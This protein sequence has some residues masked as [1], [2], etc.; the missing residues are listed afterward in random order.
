MQ[1]YAARA[2]ELDHL[3]L[4]VNEHQ[5]CLPIARKDIFRGEKR[6]PT[7]PG[8]APSNE[9]TPPNEREHTGPN[10]PCQA[11]A[12]QRRQAAAADRD[13]VPRAG[14][15]R[16]PLP[17]QALRRRHR[18]G[19]GR[20]L[21]RRPRDP[22]RGRPL[23]DAPAAIEQTEVEMERLDAHLGG[24]RWA[25]SFEVDQ[26]GRWEYTIEAWTDVFGTWRDELG[27]KVAAQQHDLS[28]ELS[29]GVQHL[30]NALKSA[31]NASEESLI[32]HA[33]E[34]LSDATIPESAKHD[35]ALGPELFRNHRADR[36]SPRGRDPGASR[37]R[38]RSTANGPSSVPGTSSS[39]DPGAG[40]EAS[41]SSSPACKSSAST[42][43][44]S[45]RSTRSATPI[46]RAATTP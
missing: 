2:R 43:S 35:V 3:R 34:T 37:S 22:P 31:Q 25:T 16:R 18:S 38:S 4:A 36:A 27:R 42:C 40:C 19:R 7:N 10:F 14:G 32:K 11:S 15:G 26:E 21:P 13:P 23:H 29:E 28:G 44:T 8:P 30:R 12:R 5:R 24:V 39:P 45:R 41:R 1:L 46:A 9:S 20:H 33:V 17:R 6:G